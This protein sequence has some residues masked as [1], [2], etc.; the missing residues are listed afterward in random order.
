MVDLPRFGSSDDMLD[1]PRL[2]EYWELLNNTWTDGYISTEE[3]SELERARQRLNISKSE[4]ERLVKQVRLT[5]QDVPELWEKGDVMALIMGLSSA[6]AELQKACLEA[7]KRMKLKQIKDPILN[8][9]D[10][11]DP[12][13]RR[14]ALEVISARPFKDSKSGVLA[15]MEDSNKFVRRSAAAALKG[16]LSRH[17]DPTLANQAVLALSNEDAVIR[18]HAVDGLRFMLGVEGGKYE[19]IVA[20]QLVEAIDDGNSFVRKHALDIFEYMGDPA[21]EMLLERGVED[22]DEHTQ[23]ASMDA[24]GR[25]NTENAIPHLIDALRSRDRYLRWHAAKGLGHHV[26]HMEATEALLE[27]LGDNDSYIRRRAAKS[28]AHHGHE[29]IEPLLE[30]TSYGMPRAQLNAWRALSLMEQQEELIQPFIQALDHGESQ[31]RLW[32][33]EGLGRC[34]DWS[35]DVQYALKKKAAEDEVEAIQH[36]SRQA[37]EELERL[38]LLTE[39]EE[40]EEEMSEESQPAPEELGEETLSSSGMV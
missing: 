34:G 26:G 37:L 3:E 21:L 40:A 29:A 20:Q 14:G 8:A 28:L 9:L 39:E 17:Q 11:K 25:L 10:H 33:V 32:A 36:A 35:E 18:R 19:G 1:E 27:A 22:D 23:R 31:I 16:L 7:L 4:H 24:I 15:A 5:P 12:W 6:E 13:R 2:E 30:L 38:R